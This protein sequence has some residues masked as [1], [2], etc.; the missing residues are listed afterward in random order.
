MPDSRFPARIPRGSS[1]TIVKWKS[2]K[3]FPPSASLSLSHRAALGEACYV[4]Q[5][6]ILGCS[7]AWLEARQSV[8]TLCTHVSLAYFY[9]LDTLQRNIILD[10]SDARK[11][12][13]CRGEHTRLR[14]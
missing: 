7:A 8:E 4:V 2:Q 13:K 12:A 1:Q 6:C 5:F 9:T 3:R 10:A 14:D 11:A